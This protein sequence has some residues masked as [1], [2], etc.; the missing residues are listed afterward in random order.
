[1]AQLPDFSALGERPLPVQPRR[2]PNIALYRP[3]SG[4]EGIPAQELARESS[5]VERTA[6]IVLIAQVQHDAVRGQDA[7]NKL[8]Q[9]AMDL[10]YGDSGY[11]KLKG[12]SAVNPPVLKTYGDQLDIAAGAISAGLDND[13]QKKAF[14]RGAQ[15]IG[16][17][18]RRGMVSHISQ[19]SDVLAKNV[20][21]ATR[22]TSINAAAADPSQTDLSLAAIDDSIN[23]YQTRQGL[24]KEW[25]DAER[26]SSRSDLYASQIRTAIAAGNPLVAADYYR[27]HFN[28]IDFKERPV[29]ENLVKRSTEPIEAKLIVDR[30]LAPIEGRALSVKEIRATLA[31]RIKMVKDDA[32]RL[33]PND[34][35]FADQVVREFRGHLE[36]I[37]AGQRGLQDKALQEGMA[38]VHGLGP[39]GEPLFKPVTMSQAM[40]DPRFRIAYDALDTDGQ[41][42]LERGI[43]MNLNRLEIQERRAET[44]ARRRERM[45][46]DNVFVVDAV[47]RIG[48]PWGASGKIYSMAELLPFY[49][50][51]YDDEKYRFLAHLI[52]EDQTRG[53][54]S[55]KASRNSRF[56]SLKP[57]FTKDQMGIPDQFGADRFLRFQQWALQKEDEYK[58]AGK[59]PTALYTADGPDDIGK[60]VNS[61]RPTL[62]ERQQQMVDEMRRNTGQTPAGAV[63]GRVG[64]LP[65]SARAR[66][67]EGQET[68]FGNGQVWTL[69]AGKAE[70]VR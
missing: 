16:L 20:F 45:P 23:L 41:A 22:S 10:S 30:A 8:R 3:T 66:L 40:R 24:P 13:Y 53:A 34:L 11:L 36:T 61:F 9:K 54:D 55:L 63:T 5:D 7:L 32:Q 17:Q 70:R 28:E 27:L 49:G 60:N 18:F 37:V 59:D 4:M 62:Q 43:D 47:R 48:L 26:R 25:A 31:D 44:A 46:V 56:T 68:T 6:G 52:N 19:Q 21:D 64:E 33:R 42:A 1:M 65:A 15:V 12:E 57:L 58:R 14:Q 2:T 67:I 69:R 51:K 50:V 29:L 38:V 39:K 35:V